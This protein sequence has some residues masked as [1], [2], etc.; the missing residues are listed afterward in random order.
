MGNVREYFSEDVGGYDWFCGPSVVSG[1]VSGYGVS[2]ALV[3]KVAV[4]TSGYGW[5][6]DQPIAPVVSTVW[7]DDDSGE[8]WSAE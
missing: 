8:Y 2:S 7:T 5:S 1:V 3:V 4:E 6:V